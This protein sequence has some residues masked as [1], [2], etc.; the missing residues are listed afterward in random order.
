[1]PEIPLPTASQ[2]VDTLEIIKFD[3]LELSQK[4][5]NLAYKIN[6]FVQS[7]HLFASAISKRILIHIKF[8]IE[9]YTQQ[10][11][12]DSSHPTDYY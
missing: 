11:G 3:L 5:V 6:N 2:M 7:K 9:R 12:E 1:M 4:A 8:I 10:T